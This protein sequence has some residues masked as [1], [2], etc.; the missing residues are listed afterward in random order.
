MR[1]SIWH[2]QLHCLAIVPWEKMKKRLKF[3]KDLR[4]LQQTHFFEKIS[5]VRKKLKHSI[6]FLSFKERNGFQRKIVE[7]DTTV[8]QEK[9]KQKMPLKA[10]FLSNSPI[11]TYQSIDCE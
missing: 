11:F 2:R 3:R 6:N 5:N 4:K 8:S 1:P 10:D 9:S 7:R